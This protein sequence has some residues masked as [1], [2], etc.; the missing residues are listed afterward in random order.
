MRF[1]YDAGIRFYYL[2]VLVASAWNDKAARW[3]AGRKNWR[4][5]FSGK[6]DNDDR[7]VWFHCASLGEFEQARTMIDMVRREHPEDKILLTFFSPSGYEKRKEYAAADVVAYLPL[8]TARNARDLLR[9]VPVSQALFIKYELWYH[10]LRR[11]R[12]QRVPVYLASA[13]F[14]PSQLFFKWYGGWYRRFLDFFTRIFVQ[15]RDS[16]VLL[17]GIGIGHVT[18]SGDTRFDRV[19]EISSSAAENKD[20]AKFTGKDPVIIAGSTWEKDEILIRQAY[21]ELRGTCKWIIAPHEP[22]EQNLQRLIKWFPEHLLFSSLAKWE[23]R[24]KADLL[25][26]DTIGHL[27]SLYRYG[28]IAYIGGG[29]G[30][31]IHNILEATAAGLPVIIGPNY[32][33]FR[34][35]VALHKA[36]AVDVAEHIDEGV[37]RIQ[38]VLKNPESLRKKSQTAKE[39][40]FRQSGATRIIV[41]YVFKNID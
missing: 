31:G 39:Y 17:K 35:A 20:V 38:G 2:M 7:V 27:S 18:V 6:F 25:I 4:E 28:T 1:I 14:T 40:T 3:I 9:L 10:F 41:D 36:G 5:Q 26:V 37:T 33:R 12:K 24:Q 30:R 21:H 8:D 11:L 16:E 32:T 34:E 29:F 23:V 22:G 15:D 13:H 19:V